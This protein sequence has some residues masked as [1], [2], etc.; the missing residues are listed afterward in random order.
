MAAQ[1]RKNHKRKITAEATGRFVFA[2]FCASCGQCLVP[3]QIFSALLCGS[4]ALRETAFSVGP[5]S[6]PPGIFDA[7]ARLGF[8]KGKNRVN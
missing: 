8:S 4:A 1:R 5:Q 6:F 3:F 7:F 2:P